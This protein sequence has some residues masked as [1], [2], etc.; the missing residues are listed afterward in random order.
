MYENSISYHVLKIK[1][2][3]TH[4]REKSQVFRS[5]D[6][7]RDT[8]TFSPM[9]DITD[10]SWTRVILRPQILTLQRKNLFV[11]DTHFRWSFSFVKKQVYDPHDW[12]THS[13]TKSK[14][15]IQV[16]LTIYQKLK[17]K[18]IQLKK[19]CANHANDLHPQAPWRP[20]RRSNCEISIFHASSSM[21]V[22]QH[23]RG[24]L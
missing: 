11:T 4:Q 10:R 13:N 21:I 19:I 6:D 24:S 1:N 23:I 14:S 7:W 16:D 5:N 20:H 22:C 8:K 15:S 9:S 12:S 17:I 3:Y 2:K 18:S